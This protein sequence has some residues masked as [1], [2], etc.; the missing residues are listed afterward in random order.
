MDELEI[1]D[2]VYEYLARNVEYGDTENPYSY[3]A[4]A[5][6]N[7]GKAVCQG[8]SSAF[9]ILCNAIGVKSLAVFNDEHMWNVVLSDGKMYHYDATFGSSDEAFYKKYCRIPDAEFVPD[10]AHENYELPTFEL[11]N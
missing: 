3:T 11:F 7:D 4:Y 5:A 9:N 2:A 6:L 1:A 10:E 8:Y